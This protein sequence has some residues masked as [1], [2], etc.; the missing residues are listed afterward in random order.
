MPVTNYV[1]GRNFEYKRRKAWQR[2]GYLVVRA[3]GS[4]SSWD[5]VAI[6]PGGAVV[7]IQ[8]KTTKS[9][10]VAKKLLSDFKHSPPLPIGQYT[11]CMEIWDEAKREFH[12]WCV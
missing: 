12:V 9:H 5:L 8:C 4:K 6:K 7:L 11:Q 3:A 1:R 2:D 10:S